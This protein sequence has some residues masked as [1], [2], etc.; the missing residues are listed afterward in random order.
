MTRDKP[1]PEYRRSGRGFSLLELVVVLTITALL[2]ALLFPGMRAARDSAHR[3]ICASNMRQLGMATI[4][5]AMDQWGERLPPSQMAQTGRRLDQMAVTWTASA[6]KNYEARELFDGLGVLISEG[7]CNSPKCL[8]CP[9]HTGRHRFEE[10]G[11]LLNNAVGRISLPGDTPTIFSN[12]QYVGD[13]GQKDTI[14][15]LSAD[16]ILITD[17]FRTKADFNHRVGM[18]QLLGDLSIQWWQ[19]EENSFFLGL[20]ESPI[21]SIDEHNEI[22]NSIW[23]LVDESY[24]IDEPSNG[25]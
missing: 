25:S 19:D 9:S 3:L 6:T 15:S 14:N 13:D 18:N 17:G 8:Y 23:G 20:P 10:N 21:I 5:Y 22:F 1:H 11:T 16:A 2:T 4:T 24:Q 12:Y 7:Y